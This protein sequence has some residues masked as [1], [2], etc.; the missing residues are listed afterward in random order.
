MERS[1]GGHAMESSQPC[2]KGSIRGKMSA[3]EAVYE[4]CRYNISMLNLA[5]GRAAVIPKGRNQHKLR[6]LTAAVLLLAMA[7]LLTLAGAFTAKAAPLTPSTYYFAEGT[8]RPN[9]D[10]YF[11]I[12]N[13]GSAAASVTLNYMKGDGTS[14]AVDVTVPKNSR[15]MVSPRDTL[16]TGDDEAHDF[17]TRVTSNQP[18][19]VERPMY[20][21]YNG[22]WTGGSDAVGAT[23]LASTYYFAEGKCRPDFDTYF[24]IQNPGSAAASVTLN[25][26]KGDGTSAAVDVTVPKNSRVTVVP[27]DTLGTGDEQAHDFSTKVTSSQPVIV[28]RPMYFNYNGVWTGGSTVVGLA[29]NPV[30]TLTS[31][32]LTSAYVGP[33][34]AI[35]LTSI[36]AITGTAQVGQTLTA[37]ALSPSGATASYQWEYSTTPG[38]TAIFGS[39]SGTGGTYTAIPGATSST[40]TIDPAYVNDYIRVAATGTGNY[41][42]TVT[43]APTEAITTNQLTVSAPTLTTTKPYDRGTTAAVTAGTLSGVISGD[44]VTV[45]AAADYDTANVGTGKTITV[46][47]TLGWAEAGKYVATVDYTTNTGVITAIRLTVSAPTLTTTKPYDRGTTAAVTAGTL[48]GVISGDTVTV[49][50]AAD[51]DTANVGTGKTIT[52]VYTLGGAEAGKYLAPVDYTTNTGVITAIRLTVSAPTLTT[53]KPYDRGTTAAVTAGTLSGVISGDTVTVNAAADY[54]TDNVGTGKTITVVYTLGGAEAGK[55]LAPVD[56]TTN[57]GVI[58]AIR[59]TV[60]APTLTTTKPYDRGTT[61]AV[62]AGTLSGVISGDTVTVNAAADYDTANVGT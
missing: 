27:R 22:V 29:G 47:Y 51:Y 43:S 53:T 50:A 61:A 10:T 23:A 40:Y 7:F 48:S 62:T 57:T 37:G 41:T 16:G 39:T 46:V 13:P 56:Y 15:V 31:I 36:G 11:C 3:S 19:I 32:S 25:Y 24:C 1:V 5:I 20:F 26:T 33:A 58:T 49:N 54:D 35:P 12:Q 6:A 4:G 21:N 52:V 18:I 9:F 30:S 59:L 42:G 28:E 55:Y 8:C 38:G 45:N 60:S 14:A 34:A 44:T 17:S 2:P